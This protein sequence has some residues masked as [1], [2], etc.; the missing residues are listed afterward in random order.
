M[1]FRQFLDRSWTKVPSLSLA[2]KEVHVRYKM[3]DKE[4][5]IKSLNPHGIKRY[6]TQFFQT[7]L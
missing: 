7:E 5:K 2:I 3:N 1:D 6:L 4:Q